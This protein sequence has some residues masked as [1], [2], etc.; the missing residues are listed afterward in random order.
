MKKLILIL[1]ILTFG[2]FASLANAA[3]VNL[4]WNA[5]PGATGYKIYQMIPT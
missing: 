4:Q 1:M 5:A 2:G 3:D